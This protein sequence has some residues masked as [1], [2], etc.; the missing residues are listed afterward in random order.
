MTSPELL[1]LLVRASIWIAVAAWAVVAG[2]G[3]RG[4][5]PR[6]SLAIWILGLAAYLVHVAAAFAGYHQWSHAAALAETAR[7]TAEFTGVPSGAGLWLNYL[8]GVLWLGDAVRWGITGEP[9]ITGRWRWLSTALHAFLAFMIFNGTVVFGQGPV[10]WFGMGLFAV[11]AV[12]WLRARL[13]PH[14]DS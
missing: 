3:W 10:R 8:V 12:G 5:F 7:Q 11:L 1:P 9:R 6:R 13:E 14:P 2:G 4:R